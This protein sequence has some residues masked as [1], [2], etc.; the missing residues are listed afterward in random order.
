MTKLGTTQHSTVLR[1]PSANSTGEQK[2]SRPDRCRGRSKVRYLEDRYAVAVKSHGR[3]D[4]GQPNTRQ[5]NARRTRGEGWE[6]GEIS[7]D[8]SGFSC[9]R[10]Q[11]MQHIQHIQ[12]NEQVGG[13]RGTP[14]SHLTPRIG[15]RKG[16]ETR[17]REGSFSLSVNGERE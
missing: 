11:Y 3:G 13:W 7:A 6:V 5:P 1:S 12:P 15:F 9:R 16:G 10:G 14:H 2:Q 8:S 4:K 17:R